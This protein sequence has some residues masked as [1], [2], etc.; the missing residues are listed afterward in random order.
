MLR[1]GSTFSEPD[2]ILIHPSDWEKVASTVATTGELVVTPDPTG[3][4]PGQPWGVP[5]V[6]TTGLTTGTGIVANLSDAAVIFEREPA[7]IK[8]DPYSQSVNN[9]VRFISE[10]R[11][12]LG[13]P[14]P[15]A[16]VRVTFNP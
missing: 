10:E 7:T 4:G 11:L 13:A 16:I 1:T 14:R 3:H 2:V 8:V 6:L 9:V 15:A 5:M 12:A